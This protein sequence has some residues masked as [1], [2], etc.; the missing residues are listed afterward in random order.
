M[1]RIN[2]QHLIGFVGALV[3][4]VSLVFMYS[5][6]ITLWGLIGLLLGIIFLTAAAQ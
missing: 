3:A 5:I 4:I 1:K 2:Y 6:G